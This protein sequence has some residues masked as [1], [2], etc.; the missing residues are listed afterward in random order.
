MRGVCVECFM[1]KCIPLLVC[2]WKFARINNY[3]HWSR[4]FSW[5]SC[6]RAMIVHRWMCGRQSQ[7][8]ALGLF[9]LFR[10]AVKAPQSSAVR[11][12]NICSYMFPDSDLF[13]DVRLSELI[14]TISWFPIQVLFIIMLSVM[15]SQTNYI[16]CCGTGICSALFGDLSIYL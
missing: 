15:F 6:A 13:C 14:K 16:L 11:V 12:I 4:S 9:Y 5:D 3:F 1:S 8:L 2:S 7:D 10:A